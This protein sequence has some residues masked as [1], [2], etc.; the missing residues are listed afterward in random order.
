MLLLVALGTDVLAA[1]ETERIGED[2]PRL[3]GVR[4]DNTSTETGLLE[5]WPTHGPPLLK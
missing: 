1:A 2:W 4:A 5:E 3:L